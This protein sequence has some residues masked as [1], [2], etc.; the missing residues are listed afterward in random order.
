MSVTFDEKKKETKV[1]CNVCKKTSFT[2]KGIASKGEAYAKAT[3]D[4]WRCKS[5]DMLVCPSCREKASEKSAAP[6]K[7][8]KTLAGKGTKA[9]LNSKSAKSAIGTNPISVGQ[10]IGKLAKTA[11]V[12]AA[13]AAE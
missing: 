7:A 13:P 8:A 3:K 4:G 10:S 6:T 1:A 12:S 5:A 11:K 2:M 9:K